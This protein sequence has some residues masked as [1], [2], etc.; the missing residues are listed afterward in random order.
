MQNTLSGLKQFTMNYID[1][2]LIMCYTKKKHVEHIRQ[3]SEH[4]QKYKMKLKLSKCEFGRNEIHS[5]GH[6]INPDRIQPLPEKNEKI[7][8]IKAPSND[9]KVC[10]LLGL[11]N[12][13]C[14][15]V[16]A[17]AD[18]M[19]PIQRLLKKNVKYEWSNECNRAF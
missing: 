14:Q 19:H 13:Y 5:L 12:Y 16:P 6:M 2:V 7:S 15:F 17:F 10:A 8:K 11:L 1:D 3:V 18:L 4:F 9:D